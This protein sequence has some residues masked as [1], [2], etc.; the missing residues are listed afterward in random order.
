MSYAT[1]VGCVQLRTLQEGH[2]KQLT[3]GIH[4]A[5]CHLL[6]NKIQQQ[7]E[8]YYSQ[9]PSPWQLS[10]LMA[11]GI[12]DLRAS[13]PSAAAHLSVLLQALQ[14]SIPCQL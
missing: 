4:V 14:G 8:S 7:H 12:A 3:S 2:S 10:V 13:L 9:Q 1:E 6:A 11:G 5:L